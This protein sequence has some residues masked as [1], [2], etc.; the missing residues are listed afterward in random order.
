MMCSCRKF[1]TLCPHELKRM[2]PWI[3]IIFPE[4]FYTAMFH[5]LAL[6]FPL[7]FS[8][9]ECITKM[10]E[11]THSLQPKDRDWSSRPEIGNKLIFKMW[12]NS[13]DA[14]DSIEHQRKFEK[15]LNLICQWG[16]E[17]SRRRKRRSKARR[18]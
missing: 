5:S 7:F 17:E 9:S 16:D 12:L 3:L 4:C 13:I 14:G 8:M 11:A 10:Y 18:H 2:S 6:I 15:L 1:F